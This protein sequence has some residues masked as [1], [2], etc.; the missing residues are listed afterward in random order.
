MTKSAGKGFP[1]RGLVA[2]PFRTVQER[3]PPP[4]R[5][6]PTAQWCASGWVALVQQR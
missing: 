3:E 4:A 5:L 6:T 2:F 1:V